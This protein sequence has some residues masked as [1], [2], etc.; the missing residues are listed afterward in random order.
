MSNCRK[1][2][3]STE[4][5]VFKYGFYLKNIFFFKFFDDYKMLPQ[6]KE[7]GDDLSVCKMHLLL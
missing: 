3:K 4:I 7:V 5:T 2:E 6:L 1:I